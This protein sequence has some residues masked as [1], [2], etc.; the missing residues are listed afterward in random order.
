MGLCNAMKGVL[1]IILTG[2]GV[3][4]AG[5]ELVEV[6]RVVAQVNDR[7]IT[8]GEI[9]L[10]MEKLNFSEEEKLLR[11]QE[12][13]DGKIDRLLSQVAFKN[14]GME[15]PV[16]YVEQEY[17]D[18]LMSDFNGDR[19][20]FREVLQ[21]NGQSPL[22]YKDQLKEDII[23]MHMLAQRKRTGDEISPQSVEDY[24]NQNPGKFRTEKRIQIKEIV[25]SEQG[26][27]SNKTIKEQAKDIHALIL[28]GQN[29]DLLAASNGQSPFL[30]KS[31]D[32]G[33]FVTPQEIRNSTIREVAFSLKEQEVSEPFR[34]NLL[35]RKANGS[36]SNSGKFAWYI[37]KI[38]NVEDAKL[39]PVDEVRSDIERIIAKDL[40]LEEQRKWLSRQKRDAYVD[41]NL[42]AK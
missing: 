17:A 27:D 9:Q 42:P 11:A 10:A 19:R 22:E 6:N 2:F 25:F 1:F 24:Y 8:W 39:L 31:G 32:W 33:V 18:K 13:V 12:F 4:L 14:K 21:S 3:H 23:H 37:L 29:F 38:E 16:T 26:T 5:A 30:K 15:L 36:I 40:E 34:V 20:L 35:E 7:V 41:I 28:N